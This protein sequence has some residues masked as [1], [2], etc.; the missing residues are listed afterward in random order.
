MAGLADLED[1][2]LAFER[3]AEA[4]V[5]ADL[6][7]DVQAALAR[8]AAAYAGLRARGPL[9]R[10]D[11]LTVAAFA[12]EQ[13]AVIR[14]NM[15]D[16]LERR[17]EDAIRL[18]AQHSRTV[19]EEGARASRFTDTDLRRVIRTVDERAQEQLDEAVALAG[20]GPIQS[21]EDLNV[22][23]A[24]ATRAHTGAAAD[25]RW[26]TNRA[27]NAGHMAVAMR[28]GLQLLWVAERDACL[29]CLAYAGLIVQ[30][31]EFFPPNLSFAA[32]PVRSPAIPYPPRHPNCRCRVRPVGDPAGVDTGLQR[33]AR[34]SVL[35]G[36]SAY[37]SERARL[38]A[39]EALL[40]RGAGLPATVERR[41]RTAV[42]AGRFET[43]AERN[44]RRR[45]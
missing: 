11:G 28:A 16:D 3:A 34:R 44:A 21:Q 25:V 35:R 14:P 26:A 6:E 22:V 23:M 7:L 45:R 24:A 18:G 9:S 2:E 17:V 15:R 29:H 8:L 27:V 30:P 38:N 40:A 33:E 5:T 42:R 36:D 4:A 43:T 37:A 12:R 32:R 10:E 31:G 1:R 13:L 20:T 39:A 41:A 19:A